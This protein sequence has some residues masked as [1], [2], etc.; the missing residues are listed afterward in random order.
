MTNASFELDELGCTSLL[1]ML[2]QHDADRASSAPVYGAL[3]VPTDESLE[4]PVRQDACGKSS[5]FLGRC[6]PY[7][8]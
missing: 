8:V 6:W 2:L 4:L 3:K 5:E 7:V 1:S